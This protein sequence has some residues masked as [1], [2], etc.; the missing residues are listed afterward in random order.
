MAGFLPKLGR[1]RVR[2]RL[3]V[4]LPLLILLVSTAV[5]SIS[6]VKISSVLQQM[7]FDH[8]LA[9]TGRAYPLL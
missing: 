4:G 5:I 1:A 2:L 7:A 8:H 9:L 6:Y 3:V